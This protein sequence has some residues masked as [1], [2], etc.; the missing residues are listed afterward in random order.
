[1]KK[2]KVF[3]V[4]DSAVVRQV[5][6]NKLQS[7]PEINVIGSAADPIF[8]MQKMQSNWP[9]VI[10]LDLEMPRMDG[11]TFLKKIMN[12]RPTAVV[13]C[14]S[15]TVNGA[16]TSI[17]ALSAG[18]VSIITKPKTAVKSFLVDE[19]EDIVQI[20]KVAAKSNIKKISSLATP[21]KITEKLTADVIVSNKVH[22]K[23][24]SSASNAI[25][26]IGTSTGGTLALEKVLTSLPS[27]SP[28]IVVVQHM[29]E[30]FT[31]AFAQRLNQLSQLEI[32]E[33]KSGD[34]IEVGRAL[35][36]PGGKHMLV[37]QGTSGYYVDIID[38][39][40]VSRHKP[41]VNV[42]FRSVAKI[43]GKNALGIIMTGMG[44]DGAQ[45]LKEMLTSGCQTIGQSESTCVVY[46]M[47]KEAK[48]IGA[49]Q[50]EVPLN[51]IADE[52]LLFAHSNKS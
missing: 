49:V 7:S 34:K 10:I 46:G 36:A 52:I 43:S 21:T 9:D 12:E 42:L 24:N 50:R 5:I 16:Q 14:S 39:P 8:A 26:A 4:D 11:I 51:K 28:G 19:S 38:G 30:N 20:V 22:K 48:K 2:I 33:A 3:I 44:D 47:P 31:N 18:A 45:G 29:P 40:P 6:T 41:S 32:N 23:I 37:K 1:M 27:N 13:I 35:I 17:Q 15:L 25:V